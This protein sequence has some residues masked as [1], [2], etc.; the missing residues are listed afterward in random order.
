MAGFAYVCTSAPVDFTRTRLMTARQMA[1]QV[2]AALRCPGPFS[3]HHT[4]CKVARQREP[5][6]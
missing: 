5:R 3:L 2:A 6:P 1:K 4:A